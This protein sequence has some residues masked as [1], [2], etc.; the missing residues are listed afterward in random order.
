MVHA[1]LALVFTDL[2]FHLDKDPTQFTPYVLADTPF[3][4]LRTSR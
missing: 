4:L 3:P 1:D 2:T